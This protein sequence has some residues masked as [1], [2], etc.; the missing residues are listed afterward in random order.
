MKKSIAII[1]YLMIMVL[2]ADEPQKP[3][4]WPIEIGDMLFSNMETALTDE[5]RT[6]GLMF[7]A[8]LPYDGGMI[9]LF[10]Q[11][12]KHS[13]WMRNTLIPLDILFI[14]KDG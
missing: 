12:E 1:I 5:A 9:F 2:S 7:R 3:L 13:F 8:S 10:K 6:R 14:D 4:L 11:S